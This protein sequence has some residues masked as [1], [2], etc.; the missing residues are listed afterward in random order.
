MSSDEQAKWRLLHLF[1][2]TRLLSNPAQLG[3][4]RA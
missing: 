4:P 2:E 3:T 1:G